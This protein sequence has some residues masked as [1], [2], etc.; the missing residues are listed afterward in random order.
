M[1]L[2]NDIAS[3]GAVIIIISYILAH[4]IHLL[5]VFVKEMFAHE[6]GAFE[7]LAAE[8]TEPLVFGQ[9]L[10]VRLHKLLNFPEN[11]TTSV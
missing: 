9:F 2:E 3:A 8:R 1:R 7:L 10:R 6:I 5:S 11:S 4:F